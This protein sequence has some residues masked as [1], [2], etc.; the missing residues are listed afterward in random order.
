MKTMQVDA[1][2]TPRAIASFV[3][4]ALE[5]AVTR[6][7]SST[8]ASLFHGMR[9]RASIH[10]Y[11]STR[12]RRKVKVSRTCLRPWPRK[13]GIERGTSSSRPRRLAC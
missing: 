4:S 12:P 2:T 6:F 9:G 8:A 11:S 13:N 3:N 10:C 7:D 5:P 1:T